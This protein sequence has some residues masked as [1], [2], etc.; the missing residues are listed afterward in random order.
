[1]S[2]TQLTLLVLAALS[3]AL[4]L[5]SS[6]RRR[7]HRASLR[8]LWHLR[9]EEL[10]AAGASERVATLVAQGDKIAAIRAYR[11]EMGVGRRAA[12]TVI[13]GLAIQVRTRQ[14]LEAGAS[15][16]VASLVATGDRIGAIKAYRHEA[17]V[18]LRAAT[19]YVDG[20]PRPA[21]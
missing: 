1:M 13:D 11:D 15:P 12:K 8:P 4:A 18:A 7:Q 10:R 2:A 19:D 16:R 20:L 21:P 17:G 9:A 3:G 5:L 6:F 14:L